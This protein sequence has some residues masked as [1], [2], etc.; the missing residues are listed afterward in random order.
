MSHVSKSVSRSARTSGEDIV[1]LKFSQEADTCML[2][3]ALHAGKSGYKAAVII[4][5]DTVVLIL[6]LGFSKD[7][8]CPICQKCG[9]QNQTRFLDIN[10]LVHSLGD[11][12]CDALVGMHA[13]TGCDTVSAFAGRGKMGALKLMKSEKTY[14][15]AFSKLGRSWNVFPDLFEKLQEI[16]GHMS[17]PATHTSEV[18]KLR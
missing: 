9:T 8:S 14:Q 1:D 6:C 12:V 16:T 4:A 13:Y 15:E 2:L 3:H 18:N 11:S 5:E 10:M 17:V 7:I